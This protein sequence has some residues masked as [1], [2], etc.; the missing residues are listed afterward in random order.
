MKYKAKQYFDR[1]SAKDMNE[2]KKMF[3]PDIELLDWDNNVKGIDEVLE[4]NN[5]LFKSV[6]SINVS[7]LKIVGQENIVFAELLVTIIVNGSSTLLNV[8]DVITFKDEKLHI[9]HAF[10]R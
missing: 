1:F 6:D 3:H 5:K 9:I 4:I 2:L 7:V 8:V 10:K